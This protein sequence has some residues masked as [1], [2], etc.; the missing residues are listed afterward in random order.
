MAMASGKSQCIICGKEKVAYRCEG[1][2][3]VYCF[4]HLSDHRQQLNQQ[5]DEIEDQ[6][7][8]FRQT[9]NEEK[10]N[11]QK[12][13]LIEQ[14]N[15]WEEDSI[16]KIRQTAEESRQLLIEYTN[17]H[18][19]KIEIKLNKLSK[20]M[21]ETRQENEVNEIVL[22]ELKNKLKQ[23]EEEL[24]NPS[25]ISIRQDSSSFISKISVII[26]SSKCIYHI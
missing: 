22:N 14:I 23:L 19:D 16:N 10:T 5:L 26:S 8:L 20:Q 7:N 2:S 12:H 6:G 25:N 18:I 1:C 17:E 24:I 13:S 4:N 11:P 15:Q 21:H 9:L 3:K